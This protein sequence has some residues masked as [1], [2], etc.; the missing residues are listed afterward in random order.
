MLSALDAEM[1]GD[2]KEMEKLARQARETFCKP[3]KKHL[4]ASTKEL[5]QELKVGPGKKLS[6]FFFFF[7]LPFQ[8]PFFPPALSVFR[9]KSSPRSISW[10]NPCDGRPAIWCPASSRS[11]RE[12]PP[13]PP[14]WR[15]IF[16]VCL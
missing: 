4:G 6:C 9:G 16:F 12:T 10:P 1:R 5:K 3:Q 2:R 13:K 14:S 7:L 8:Q 15:D 11:S